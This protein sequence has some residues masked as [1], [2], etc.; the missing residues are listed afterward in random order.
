MAAR[1]SKNVKRMSALINDILDF[2]RTRLGGGIGVNI[3]A[4]AEVN[5]A[6]TEVVRELQDAQP[7]REIVTDIGAMRTVRCDI[8]RLQQV[9]SNLIANALMHGDPQQPV[10]VSAYYRRER[11]CPDCLELG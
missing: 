3:D 7:G 10:K 1:I 9:A 4:A 8:S 5:S 2:A 6:L 11:V